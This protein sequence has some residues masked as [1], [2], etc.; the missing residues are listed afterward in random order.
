M[1][2]EYG[3][4]HVS[5]C[6]FG[7][8]QTT[9]SLPPSRAT[10]RSAHAQHVHPGRKYVSGSRIASPPECAPVSLSGLTHCLEMFVGWRNGQYPRRPD[11]M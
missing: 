9:R 3:A 5:M 1:F 4:I 6:E 7:A 11:S 2:L 8:I 10:T